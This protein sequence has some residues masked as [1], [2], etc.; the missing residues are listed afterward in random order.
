TQPDAEDDAFDPTWTIAVTDVVR[1]GRKVDYIAKF[2][3]TAPTTPSS[4]SSSALLGAPPRAR[5]FDILVN[6]SALLEQQ[7]VAEDRT[8][9]GPVM[10]D[11]HRGKIRAPDSTE[12]DVLNI[13]WSY[14]IP[15]E[16][17]GHVDIPFFVP[18]ARFKDYTK[19]RGER[20]TVARIYWEH[21][22]TDDFG[23]TAVNVAASSL[24]PDILETQYADALQR[25]ARAS[26]ISSWP[27]AI[28]DAERAGHPYFAKM[29]KIY[30]VAAVE[31][32]EHCMAGAT[33]EPSKL[34]HQEE[35]GMRGPGAVELTLDPA[36]RDWVLLPLTFIMLASGLVR[37]YVAQLMNKRPKPIPLD[38]LRE[39]RALTRGQ[40]LRSS[41]SSLPPNAFVSIK[42][43]LQQSYVS[44]HYLR[45]QAN[46]GKKRTSSSS[47]SARPGQQADEDS[48][49][50]GANPMD[51][52]QMDG[53]IDMI[54]KQAVGF[55][56]Q[57]VLMY[58]INSFF[59]GFLLTRLPFPLTIRFKEMLQR[60]LVDVPDLDASWCS[61][62]SW[63]FLCS[64]GL[65][66][67]YRLVLGDENAASDL[68][69]M[70]LGGGG[71]GGGGGN[72]NGMMPPV[73]MPGQPQVDY[74]KLFRDEREN[75]D[76]VEYEW[77]GRGVEERVLAMFSP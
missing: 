24:T 52:A 23:V 9:I 31:A 37:H 65:N 6:V 49:D 30:L 76:I 34:A 8:S 50:P 68:Q 28:D 75:L 73:M 29:Y 16:R 19:K 60:G 4:S 1:R 11:L 26:K 41:C 51:P 62:I 71:G 46:D 47:K 70:Q 13:L 25:A 64:F 21:E 54:K 2:E 39:Q 61:S 45:S 35:T 44:G 77:V 38:Q 32:F 56:P 5:S 67:V 14:E 57:T 43:H 48:A 18:G 15:V 53:M 20:Y 40:L 7:R 42:Q 10:S 27:A 63:F 3:C 58:Y 12:A 36:I 59:S 74:A 22:T 33:S 69:Q 55:L 17:A 66:P 72:G